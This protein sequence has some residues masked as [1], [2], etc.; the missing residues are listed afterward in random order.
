MLWGWLADAVLVAHIGFVTFVVLGGLCVLRW[1]TLA[2]AH[3]P[4]VLWGVLIE[5]ADLVCPLTP[6]EIAFRRRAGE[7]GYASSFIEHYI[8]VMLYPSA[9]TRGFQIGLGTFALAINIIVYWRL[10]KGS[11]RP[12]A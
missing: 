4:A 3:A 11:G 12:R 6:L 2:W 1:P 7:M 5:Y 10:A 9:L 8:G